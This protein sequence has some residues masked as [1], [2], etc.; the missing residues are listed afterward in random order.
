MKE[1]LKDD[2]LSK[3]RLTAPQTAPAAQAV[4]RQVYQNFRISAFGGVERSA[5]TSATS[6][7]S[8]SCQTTIFRKK[9][10]FGLADI[11]ELEAWRNDL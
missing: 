10:Q 2:L 3:G 1:D 4:A 6:L 11:T 9:L 5:D 8:R 7:Y